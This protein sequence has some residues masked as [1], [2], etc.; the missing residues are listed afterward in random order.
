MKSILVFVLLFLCNSYIAQLKVSPKS[1][2]KTQK[3]HG[4]NGGKYYSEYVVQPEKLKTF[5]H[6][7]Q[8]PSSF[9]KYDKF[10]SYDENKLI[11]K[12]WAKNNKML[13]KQEYWYKFEK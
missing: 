2:L 10:K 8:I 9:P 3:H 12:Q 5:F 11:A 4:N 13:I 7:G 1:S 6:S